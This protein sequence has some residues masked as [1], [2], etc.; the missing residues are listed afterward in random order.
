MNGAYATRRRDN[1]V[2]FNNDNNNNSNNMMF[3]DG[4]D[5]NGVARSS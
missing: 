5:K 4:R 3:P 2:K 1:A